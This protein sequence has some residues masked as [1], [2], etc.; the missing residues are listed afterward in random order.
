MARQARQ[1]EDVLENTMEIHAI[2]LLVDVI[3]DE[4]SGD[5]HGHEGTLPAPRVNFC[6]RAE[7]RS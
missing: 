4:Q 5:V 6:A 7:N 3:T 2:E 1:L